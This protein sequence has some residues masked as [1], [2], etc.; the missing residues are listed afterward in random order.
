[1]TPDVP[2][3]VEEDSTLYF[4]VRTLGPKW[5]IISRLMPGRSGCQVKNR[6]YSLLRT[7]EK[8]ILLDLGQTM[9]I[10][11]AV[12]RKE[13]IKAITEW[14]SKI[15][16]R[17]EHSTKMNGKEIFCVNRRI[18]IQ[19]FWKKNYKDLSFSKKQ[20]RRRIQKIR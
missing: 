8:K 5:R 11:S 10:R 16:A 3:I 1:M 12:R 17:L 18:V 19:T 13:F 20:Y 9:G 7:R 15:D 2:W 6:W 4:L 14:P